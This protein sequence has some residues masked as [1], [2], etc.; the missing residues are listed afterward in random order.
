MAPRSVRATKKLGWRVLHELT[1]TVTPETLLPWHRELIARKYDG[2]RRRGPG[3]PRVQDEIHPWVARMATENRDW[4]YP[5]MQGALANLG[6]EVARA[7]SPTFLRHSSDFFLTHSNR[8]Q[9]DEALPSILKYGCRGT[10]QSVADRQGVLDF[11]NAGGRGFLLSLFAT[12]PG[13]TRR[14]NGDQEKQKRSPIETHVPKSFSLLDHAGAQ[15]SKNVQK[16]QTQGEQRAEQ[17][18]PV[19]Q[20]DHLF[21]HEKS[22]FHVK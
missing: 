16:P 11:R 13:V 7:P 12:H 10:L 22:P 19:A 6:R 14:G 8:T 20:S 18:H 4:G 3:R 21:F 1:T 5:R 2:R 15:Y 9:R 17:T